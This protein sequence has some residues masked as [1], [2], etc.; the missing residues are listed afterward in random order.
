MAKNKFQKSYSLSHEAIALI[1]EAAKED[2]RSPS[3]WLDR[4]IIKMLKQQ[5]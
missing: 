5:L 4:F 3:D 1:K 2:H